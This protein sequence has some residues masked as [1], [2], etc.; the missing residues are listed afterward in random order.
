MSEDNIPTVELADAQLALKILEE[1]KAEGGFSKS[2]EEGKEESSSQS[3][4]SR[5]VTVKKEEETSKWHVCKSIT[6]CALVILVVYGVLA[7]IIFLGDQAQ[8]RNNQAVTD[9]VNEGNIEVCGADS[10]MLRD[11]V[12]DEATNNEKCLYDGGDCCLSR[13]KK[14]ESL[15]KVRN[16]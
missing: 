8:T 14:G 16:L 6:I 1:F 13:G 5:P 4:S 10:F 11:G 3:K 15:C 7:F 2:H 12:C 9:N